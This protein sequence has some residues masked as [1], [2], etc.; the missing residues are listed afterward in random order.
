MSTDVFSQTS[1]GKVAL[2]KMGEVP[3]D[4]RLYECG[5]MDTERSV[6]EVIGA[7]F[8]K[9]KSGKNKGKVSIL[10]KGTEQRVLV[11]AKEM[12]AVP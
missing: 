5:W 3:E 1:Y 9:A 7:E 11:T 4:F 8:R 6:M 10:I 12:E 2:T